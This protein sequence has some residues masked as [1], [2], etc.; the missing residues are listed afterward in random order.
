MIFLL[1][2]ILCGSFSCESWRSDQQT[3]LL[4]PDY[5]EVFFYDEG[6]EAIGL[7]WDRDIALRRMGDLYK[8]AL[9]PV[10]LVHLAGGVEEAG[11]IANGSRDF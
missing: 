3:G 10:A 2:L 4:E 7:V 9:V 6:P 5:T 1:V 11:A 8:K